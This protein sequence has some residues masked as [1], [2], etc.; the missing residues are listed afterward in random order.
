MKSIVESINES[1][2]DWNRLNKILSDS[3]THKEVA[4]K[5]GVTPSAVAAV[6]S[7]IM[8]KCPDIDMSKEALVGYL[9]DNDAAENWC[10]EIELEPYKDELDL[11]GDLK[12][13]ADLCSALADLI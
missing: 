5:V 9:S 12:H 1:R 3:K 2:I 6:C 13:L 8:E 4:K 11:D 7:M 10:E